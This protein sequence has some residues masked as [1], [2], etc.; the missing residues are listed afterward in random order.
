[1]PCLLEGLEI[2]QQT[3][4]RDRTAQ[5]ERSS[6]FPQEARPNVDTLA[7]VCADHIHNL[8]QRF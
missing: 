4:E 1:M 2:G 6:D 7:P 8:T 5:R 3:R